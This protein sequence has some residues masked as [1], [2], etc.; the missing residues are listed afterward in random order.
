MKVLV[1]GAN[2][3]VA[4]ALIA[5]LI[6]NEHTV[7]AGARDISKI[8]TD[9]KVT[10]IAIDLEKPLKE[11]NQLIPSV[12]V[13]YFVAGS[14]GKDLLKV[15]AFGAIKAMQV[16]ELKNI[17]RFVMLSSMFSLEPEKWSSDTPSLVNYRIAKFFADNY[18]VTNTNLDYTI[19]QPT[20]LTETPGTGKIT[21]DNGVIDQNSITDVANTLAEIIEFK[22]TVKKVIKMHAGETPIKEA[23]QQI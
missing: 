22:N 8:N 11:L 23:L 4:K 19:V 5:K 10:R 12:D 2:G 9:S 14:R 15:D 21:I 3:R 20:R 13:I 16:A 17:K 7:I 18:L 1:I 6:K